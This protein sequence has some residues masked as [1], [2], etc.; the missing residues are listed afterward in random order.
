MK[1]LTIS[2]LVTFALSG[3]LAADVQY[4]VVAF[5]SGNQGVA[6]SVN[7]QTVQLQKSSLHPNI[8][9]GTA[10]FGSTYQYVITDGQNKIPE[11]TTRKLT[12][13]ITSTGNEFFN[14][15]QTIYNVPALPQAFNPVY[16]TLFTNMNQSNEVST[17]IMTVNATQLEAFNKNPLE[18]LDDAQ[19]TELAYINSK[20]VYKFTNAGLSTS[21]QSTKDF[22]K[23]SWAIELDKYNKNTTQKS[24]LFGRTTLKLRA[25]ETDSTFAREKLVLDMLAAAGGATLSASWTRVF[26]NNEPYGLFLLMDDVSTHLIDNVLHGGNWKSPNTGVTYKGNALSPEQEGNLVYVGDDLTKYSADLYKLADKGED[27]SV[28][29]NN[30]QQ[31][32]MEFCK[33]LSQVNYK[34][35]TDAQHP[36]SIANLIDSPQNTLIHLAINF[37]IGSWD[38]FWYQASNYYL[39]QDLVTKKWTLI[40]YDFDET[41]GNGVEDAG[42]NTVSYQNYSRP[43]SERPLVT[44]FLNN[45]YYQ[46]VFENTLKTIVKR[47]FKPSVINPRLQAWSEMLKEDIAWTRAIPGRSPGTKTTFTV[48]NF[49]DG[50]LGNGTDAISQWVTKRVT[51]IT[52]QLNF[53]DTDDLPALPAYT[54][55]T[56][57]DANGNV[58]SSNGSTVSTGSNGNPSGNGNSNNASTNT[59]A[60]STSAASISRISNAAL[61][62]ASAVVLFHL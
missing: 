3:T 55:G 24:L 23:Q 4:S 34:D 62:V 19:V 40:T 42:M 30:S 46:G 39:N 61:I 21:G 7:G 45:T 60:K 10:P 29:K 16:P 49:Q 6:V 43:G 14:R 52:S 1:F 11:T 47:F 13:G 41:F 51:S 54:A 53:S 8:F 59:S 32:I 15:S 12:D 9:S 38:G 27:N 22:A 20:E 28:S 26:I 5:P 37:L 33:N 44:V 48:Q 18:K 50:L 17:I 36:G 25:E 58:V 2:A 35:A 56:H 57:L 31:L